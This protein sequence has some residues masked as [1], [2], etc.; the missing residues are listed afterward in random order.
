MAGSEQTNPVT[1]WLSRASGPVFSAYAITAAFSVYFCMYA[2]RKPFA[3]GM[4]EGRIELPGLPSMSYKILLIVAQVLGYCLSKFIGIKVVSEMGAGRRG[5]AIVLAIAIAEGALGMFAITPRPWDAVWLFVNGLPL[6]VVW[7]LV[8]GYLEGRRLSEVLGAGLSASYIVASGFVKSV[9][10]WMLTLGISEQW[11]P[12]VTGLIFV[13][14]MLAFVYMLSL[15]PPPSKEDEAER[16]KRVPM[17]REARH[18]FLKRYG[19]GLF[20]LTFLYMFLTAYRDFRDNFAREIWDA[21][22]YGD[23][24]SIFTATEIPIA[25]AVLLVLAAVMVIRDNRKALLV[26]HGIMAAG[27]A[28]IGLS[29]LAYQAELIG[30]V[31]WMVLVGLGLYVGYVPFGCVLFDRLIAA[32]G[33]LATAGFMIYVTDA[34]GYLGSVGVLLYKTFGFAELSWVNFF[35]RF[36][37]ATS[38]VCTAFFV[39]SMIYFARAARRANAEEPEG[40]EEDAGVAT[41]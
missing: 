26:V 25:F 28:L 27:S 8:F 20:S 9:G 34:F 17:D 14:I 15:L 39:I 3:V 29:T 36:S 22:G 4:F 37:Y 7:G 38:A 18:S 19:F 10:R 6:G 12:F 35:I 23:E 21:V 5:L 31:P 40:G 30:P 13:P 16:V 41:V 1:R 32:V 33:H 2:F 24:P 11:M